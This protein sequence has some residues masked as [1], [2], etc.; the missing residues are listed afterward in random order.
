[1]SPSPFPPRYIE[2]YVSRK[3]HMQRHV[4]YNQQILAAYPRVRK[5]P[6]PLLE[7]RG[8]SSPGVSRSDEETRESLPTTRVLGA[9]FALL[10]C[11]LRA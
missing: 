8:L 9:P 1:M 11:L 2:V 10:P 4:S 3:H 5:E 6:E 7:E